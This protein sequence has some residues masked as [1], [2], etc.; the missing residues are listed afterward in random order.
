MC[1]YLK[2]EKD[3][4]YDGQEHIIP[5]GLGCCTKLDTGVVSDK[6]NKYFSKIEHAGLKCLGYMKGTEGYIL[7]QFMV[8]KTGEV[9]FILGSD[10]DVDRQVLVYCR[11]K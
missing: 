4:T 11:I 1:I 6:A 8:K 10:G 9:S 2:I 5:A 3:L 7:N